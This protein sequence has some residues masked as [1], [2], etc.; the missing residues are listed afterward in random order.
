MQKELVLLEPFKI[1]STWESPWFLRQNNILKKTVCVHL[2]N[3]TQKFV[4]KAVNQEERD[5]QR[6][7]EEEA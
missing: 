2:E 6:E 5:R 1:I 4:H 3:L 7:G